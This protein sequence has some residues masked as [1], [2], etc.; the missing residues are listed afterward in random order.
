MLFTGARG[1]A[2]GRCVLDG[3]AIE[4]FS[5]ELPA[6]IVEAHQLAGTRPRAVQVRFV[7]HDELPAVTVP[8]GAFELE[9]QRLDLGRGRPPV[10]LQRL[11]AADDGRSNEEL[12]LGTDE[13]C[14]VD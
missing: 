6:M 1:D 5:R 14:V 4:R 8:D 9:L 13:G 10:A 11:L 7:E 3:G 12:R 2:A